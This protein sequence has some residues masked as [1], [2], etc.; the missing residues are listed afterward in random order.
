MFK[1][2]LHPGE[3]GSISDFDH[4]I[5]N[6][7]A[8]IELYQ[9]TFKFFVLWNDDNISS[10]YGRNRDDYIHLYPCQFDNYISTRRRLEK[11]FLSRNG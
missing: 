1:Y 10:F 5:V 6:F 3:F 11:E 8:L 4:H 2:A 7:I 9:L